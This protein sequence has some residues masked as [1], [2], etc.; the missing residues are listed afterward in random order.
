MK[1]IHDLQEILSDLGLPDYRLRQIVKNVCHNLLDDYQECTDLPKDLRDTLS[2]RAPILSIKPIRTQVSIRK[3]TYKTLFETMDGQKIESVLMRFQDGRN[4]LCISCQSGCQMGCRFCATGTMGLLKHLNYEEIF[5]QA[6]YYAQLLKKENAVLTNIVFMGMGEPF[7]NYDSVIEAANLLSDPD[8][9]GLGARR[10][11]IST[12]GVVPGILKM[13]DEPKQYNLALSL[14]A[15]DQE[16][17]E[18]IMPIAKRWPITVLMD[19]VETYLDKTRRRISYEYVMLKDVNDTEAQ[20]HMLGE[21]VKDHLCHINLIPYN[22]TGSQFSCT[23]KE[24]IYRFRDILQ[25]YGLKVTVR[26][27]MGQDIDAACGQLAQKN[28]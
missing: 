10:I 7:M 20:A 18:K 9:L 19:A 3:D 13:A 21:L 15:P 6:L 8:Y 28:T 17:R 14:H 2:E 1:T 5:D 23:T 25:E 12:S 22:P 16:T 24:N 27:T 4:S 11:T 26:V